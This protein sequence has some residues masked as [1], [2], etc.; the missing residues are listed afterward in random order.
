MTVP[1][2]DRTN[3]P[4]LALCTPLTWFRFSLFFFLVCSLALA[5]IVSNDFKIWVLKRV[6][7][8]EIW[9]FVRSAPAF[10]LCRLNNVIFRMCARQTSLKYT[11]HFPEHRVQLTLNDRFD[12]SNSYAHHFVASICDRNRHCDYHLNTEN[13]I[14]SKLLGDTNLFVCAQNLDFN[15]FR[16]FSQ[17]WSTKQTWKSRK[18]NFFIHFKPSQTNQ[19][20]LMFWTDYVIDL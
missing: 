15:E 20:I 8:I 16:S 18:I 3:S 12:L 9:F 7:E 13:F 6:L 17:I 5:L 2:S 11:Q 4:S 10:P 19:A 14:D 1:Y